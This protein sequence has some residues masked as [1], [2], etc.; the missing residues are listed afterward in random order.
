MKGFINLTTLVKVFV[1]AA[2]L[3][4]AIQSLAFAS[5]ID[6][7]VH[8]N[9]GYTISELYLSQSGHPTWGQNILRGTL[10]SGYYQEVRYD[11][12]F[13]YFDLT[14]LRENSPA[15]IG[16]GMNRA[17]TTGIFLLK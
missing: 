6:L 12:A 17:L 7:Q 1:L 9:T 4:T 13:T 14:Y 2:F 15:S 10:Q 3:I 16:G 11:N 5:W 8:N